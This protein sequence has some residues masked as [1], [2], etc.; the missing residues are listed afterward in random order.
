MKLNMLLKLTIHNFRKKLKFII[1]LNLF[2]KNIRKK[3]NDHD[4]AVIKTY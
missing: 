4:G 2:W 1:M 3:V